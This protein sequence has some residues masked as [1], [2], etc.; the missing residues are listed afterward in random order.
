MKEIFSTVTKQLELF[1]CL[2]N[3]NYVTIRIY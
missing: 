2:N 1:A 3:I